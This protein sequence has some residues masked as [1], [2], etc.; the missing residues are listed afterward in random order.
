MQSSNGLWC[1]ATLSAMRNERCIWHPPVEED[2]L[3]GN[4]GCVVAPSGSHGDCSGHAVGRRPV[5]HCFGL[6]QK[7]SG[8]DAFHSGTLA[9]RHL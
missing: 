2:A 8:S 4:D 1:T 7:L 3:A 9:T 5:H 6:R